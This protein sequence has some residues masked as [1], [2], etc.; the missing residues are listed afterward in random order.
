MNTYNSQYMDT[1]NFRPP[2][3]LRP[4]GSQVETVENPISEDDHDYNMPFEMN[5]AQARTLPSLPLS[6]TVTNVHYAAPG[7][8]LMGQGSVPEPHYQDPD[9]LASVSYHYMHNN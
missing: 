3:N 6:T 2:A 7:P 5:A 1:H 4:R 8:G 9:E